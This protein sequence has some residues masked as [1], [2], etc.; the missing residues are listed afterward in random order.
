MILIP[1]DVVHAREASQIGATASGSAAN[2]CY[3]GQRAAC[4]PKAVRRA[5]IS[6]TPV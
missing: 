4:L 1:W 3:R 5:R 2:E 6:L